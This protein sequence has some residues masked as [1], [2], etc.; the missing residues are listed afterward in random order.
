MN[1]FQFG[2]GDFFGTIIPGAFLL[3]NLVLAIPTADRAPWLKLDASVLVT[4]M[5]VASYALWFGLRLIS[6]SVVEL[7]GA[8]VQIAAVLFWS[9][10]RRYILE[11]RDGR[12]PKA[13]PLLK[14]RLWSSVQPYPYIDWFFDR[15]L[16]QS[17]A[18]FSAFFGRLVQREFSGERDKLKNLHFINQCKLHV[19]ETSNHLG[20]E[21]IQTEGLVRFVAGMSVALLTS[22]VLILRGCLS[23]DLPPMVLPTYLTV[24]VI[25]LHRLRHVRVREVTRI[26]IC[27]AM[28]LN[29]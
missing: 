9:A 24:L 23:A 2:R 25:F 26:F 22:T 10:P 21:L 11:R 4:V 5:L 13:W 27:F 18:S 20:E 1:I 19:I 6:P 15:Y 7:V 12:H 16:P 29:K 8:P 14:E 3:L 28:C 17:P